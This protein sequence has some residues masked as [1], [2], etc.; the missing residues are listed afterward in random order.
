MGV[1]LHSKY[2]VI[3]E[4]K[5]LVPITIYA[6]LRSKIPSHWLVTL[7]HLVVETYL[8]ESRHIP[9]GDNQDQGGS[10]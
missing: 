7:L 8:C 1:G 10:A 5:T 9:N 3:A 2:C 4:S 6:G